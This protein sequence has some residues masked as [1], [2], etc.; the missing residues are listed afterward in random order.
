MSLASL[1]T[2]SADTDTDDEPHGGDSIVPPLAERTS[3]ALALCMFEAALTPALKHLL[4][5][6]PHLIVI[7]TADATAAALLERHLSAG[8]RSIMVAAYTERQKTGGRYEPLGR[9]EL[10]LLEKG[11]SVILISH[12]PERVLVPEAL[13]GADATMAVPTPDLAVIRKTIRMVTGR[14]VRCLLAADVEGLSIHDLTVAIRPGLASRDCVLNLRRMAHARRKPDEDDATVSLEQLAMTQAV[15]DWA[16]ETL[17]LMRHA[18][19]GKI[20]SSALRF[21]C[22]EGPPGTGKT[23]VAA[24][25]ARSAEWRFVSTSV[26]TWF[27]D[28]G[29]H[30]GDVI[31][32]A[33]KF[34]DDIALS[35]EPVVGL[36]D[37]IDAIPNRATMDAD[38]ASWWTPVITFLLTEI[39]RLRKSGK[40]VMLIGATNHFDR[41]D[42]ALIRPGRLEHKVSVLLP[43]VDDRRRM[44]AA[45]IGDRIDPGS[46]APLARL[47]VEATPAQI[48]SWCRS[49]TAKAATEERQ[50]ALTDLM[51]LIAPPN[52]RSPETDRGIAIHEAGHA[53]V[54]HALNLPI[55]EV[56]I[57]AAGAMGGWV[58]PRLTDGLLTRSDV[59]NLVTMVLA[60]R[61]ADTVL[62]GGAN[63][64]AE[65]DLEI[66]NMAL[67]SAM[68][69][70]GLFGTLTTGQNVD[71]RHWN[72]GASLWEA[73][74]AE[75]GRLHD[76]AVKI[77]SQR[78]N[79][80]FRLV[81]ILLVE[82]VITGDRLTEI[83]DAGPA[84]EMPGK[85]GDA[86]GAIEDHAP[87]TGRI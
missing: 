58:K 52:G 1:R 87:V 40:P 73:I 15:S 47:A 80:I 9:T 46:I 21:A 20:D 41:L 24:A 50:L 75:L 70:L 12:D 44:F 65:S 6:R 33:R 13:V 22:L 63:S 81:E 16:F 64:G 53:V 7:K 60:G 61:A 2:Q 19:D 43:D 85:V 32:A 11:R 26:G 29:G 39:D 49:A 82:R 66:A 30:L 83:L 42:K 54:A 71:P 86:G 35:K 74:A 78:R 69:D 59:E 17:A 23:T 57:V 18:T 28:S 48:E 36:M 55:A 84:A 3:D 5:A 45:Y 68:L 25:L 67:R 27:A 37:E 8:D 34:F 38:D 31:R 56:S 10:D 14:T 62:G 76:R 79:D 77:V 72:N 51:V 4:K